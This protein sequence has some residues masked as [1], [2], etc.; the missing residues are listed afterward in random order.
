M[1]MILDL[2]GNL[3]ETIFWVYTFKH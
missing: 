1:Q 2:N 3:D